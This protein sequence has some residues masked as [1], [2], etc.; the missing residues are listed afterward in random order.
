MR[1]ASRSPAT[2]FGKNLRR[3]RTEQGLSQLELA[4]KAHV[5]RNTIYA[6]EAGLTGTKRGHR[7]KTIESIINA[8][9]CTRADLYGDGTVSWISGP[10]RAR[11]AAELLACR[12]LAGTVT[13]AASPRV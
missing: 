9:G 12:F 7:A 2:S 5:H 10:S 8:L 3:I 1:S 11:Q 13:V 6:L 4:Q